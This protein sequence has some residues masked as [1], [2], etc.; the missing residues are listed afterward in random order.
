MT[1]FFKKIFSAPCHAPLSMSSD[2][3]LQGGAQSR[4]EEPPRWH[5]PHTPAALSDCAMGENTIKSE[6]QGLAPCHAPL[7]ITS[8]RAM[9]GGAHSRPKDPHRY[10]PCSTL[11]LCHGGIHNHRPRHKGSPPYTQATL[12][13][14]V[15]HLRPCHAGRSSITA[16]GTHQIPQWSRTVFIVCSCLEFKDHGIQ[17]FNHM[18]LFVKESR[19]EGNNLRLE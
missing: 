15:Y 17:I 7:S 9:H 1:A 10:T 11:E 13:S 12:Y 4:P 2:S 6:A 3:A 16:R 5:T 19:N 14:S 8:D 18:K